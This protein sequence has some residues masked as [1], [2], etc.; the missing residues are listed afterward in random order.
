MNTE[1]NHL[2]L[3]KTH[4]WKYTHCL[5]IILNAHRRLIMH[6]I[7]LKKLFKSHQEIGFFLSIS[8]H[9]NFKNAI[10]ASGGQAHFNSMEVITYSHRMGCLQYLGRKIITLVGCLVCLYVFVTTHPTRRTK[11]NQIMESL[12]YYYY[13][14][15]RLLYNGVSKSL[16]SSI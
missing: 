10:I 8:C 5:H 3:S 12:S 6:R 11:L 4:H 9:S 16:F 2:H 14:S 7:L 15:C 13:Y 1:K